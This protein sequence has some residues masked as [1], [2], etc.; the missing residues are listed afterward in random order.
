MAHNSFSPITQAGADYMLNKKW[1][2]FVDCRQTWLSV[3]AH[4]SLDGMVPV[5]AHLKLYPTVVSAGVTYRF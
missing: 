5:K 2:A 3:D 1:G 4:G